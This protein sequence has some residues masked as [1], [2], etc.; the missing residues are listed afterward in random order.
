[1]NRKGLIAI[2]LSVA[3][4]GSASIFARY[5]YDG[6]IN[7]TTMLTVRFG[8][9]AALLFTASRISRESL[10]LAWPDLKLVLLLGAI[11]YG[12]MAYLYFGSLQHIPVSMTALITY[13]YPTIVTVMAFFLRSEERRVG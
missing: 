6:G 4:F 5:A 9:S 12:C 3:C 13:T 11:G 1:M 8:I 7:L 10:K 2:L